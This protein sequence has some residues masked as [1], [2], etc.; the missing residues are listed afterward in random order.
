M[1]RH[2]VAVVRVAREKTS[3]TQV[4]ESYIVLRALAANAVKH[5]LKV[6]TSAKPLYIWLS[7]ISFRDGSESNTREQ[8]G[9]WSVESRR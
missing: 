3:A 7:L 5:V 4:S 8:S 2:F 9:I 6:L 1:F